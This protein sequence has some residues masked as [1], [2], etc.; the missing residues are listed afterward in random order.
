[1]KECNVKGMIIGQGKPKVCLPIVG[2]DDQD[3]IKQANQ[4]KD[5]RFD[6]VELRIDFY[7]EILNKEAILH[8]LKELRSII[9]QPIL[10]TYRSKK[11]GGQVQLDSKHYIELIETACSSQC[12]DLVDIEL[13]SGNLL[14]YKLV[15]I[16]HKYDV[17]VVISNHDFE[18]TP[19]SEELCER[20]DTMEL[21]DADICKI[22]VMPLNKEDVI[23][24]LEVTSKMSKKLNKP[25]I[26][27]SMGNLGIISRISGEMFGSAVTF[28]CNEL[29]SAPGQINIDD[30]NRILEV[31]H[32]D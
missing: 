9:K 8:I 29:A 25:L 14:V 13:M 5:K 3:I 16:A 23:R 32:N 27:M 11:E 7:K 21:L 6:L 17:K 31:L 26:T 1:M 28:A 22:A 20:L 18:R 30:M 19:H 2:V 12:I 10:F 24:L 15:D 4:L